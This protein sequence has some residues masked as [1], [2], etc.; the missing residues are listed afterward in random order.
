MTQQ[1]D[2]TNEDMAE[3]VIAKKLIKVTSAIDNICRKTNPYGAN[4]AIADW[5]I[6]EIEQAK[7]DAY[8]QACEDCSG[9]IGKLALH[10]LKQ[11]EV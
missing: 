6:A 9:A 1:T 5:H 4:A 8:K 2:Q 3:K 10:L 11:S 7:R